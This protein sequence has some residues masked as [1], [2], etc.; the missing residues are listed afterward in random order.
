ML[1]NKWA[2]LAAAFILTASFA[3]QNIAL[4]TTFAEAGNQSAGTSGT[5]KWMAGEYHA[6]TYVSD[7]AQQSVQTVLDQAFETYGMDWM[8]LSDHLRTSKRDDEGN[9]LPSPISFKDA[10]NKYQVNIINKLKEAGK[11]KDK[12]I[13]QGLSGICQPTITSEQA[14]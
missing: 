9:S 6:H 4:T 1:S 2:K 5:G 3:G 7:D 11:Y 12:I 14:Y 10:V 8:N 13:F